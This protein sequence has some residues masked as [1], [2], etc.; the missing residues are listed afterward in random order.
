MK[1]VLVILFFLIITIMSL[2]IT[3]LNLCCKKEL[4]DILGEGCNEDSTRIDR[5]NI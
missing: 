3:F 5:T 2:G 4:W 1:W